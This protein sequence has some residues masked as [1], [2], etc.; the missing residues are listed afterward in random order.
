MELALLKSLLNK[1]FYDL[2]K[3]NKCPHT[4]FTKNLGKVKTLIDEAMRKYDRDLNVNELES[5]YMSSAYGMSTSQGEEFKDIFKNMKSEN[6]LGK[7]VADTV[8]TRLFQRKLGQEISNIGF[9]YV[10]GFDPSLG[11]LRKILDTHKDNFLPDLAIEWEDISLD[12]ILSLNSLETRWK[13]N[14]P[15]LASRVAG[16]NAGHLIMGAARP[17][18]GKTSFHASMV[19]GPRGFASQGAKCIVLVNEEQYHRVVFRY[20]CA[21][22]NMTEEQ[23]HANRAKALAIWSEVSKNI[24]FKDSTGMDLNWVE[25]VCKASKAD[26]V[27]LDM[28]DKFAHEQTH[29]GLKACA[30]HARQIAKEHQCAL[31]YMSQLSAAAQGIASPDQSMMEGSKTGKASEADLMIFVAKDP[32]V[33]GTDINDFSRYITIAKNKLSG[34]HGRMEVELDYTTSRYSG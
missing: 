30:I 3:G 4:L 5:L 8:L 9:S 27:I 16:V 13:F 15:K 2:Y 22:T 28:G 12:T 18:T 7:D 26:V 29:E 33:E 19:A 34:W 31:F 25:Y 6:S 32:L 11:T 10:N 20:V 21:A 24:M 14:L 17:N 1:D 23:V